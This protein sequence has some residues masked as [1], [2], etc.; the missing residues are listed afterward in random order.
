MFHIQPFQPKTLTDL[1]H[2][3]VVLHPG[4]LQRLHVM[5]SAVVVDQFPTSFGHTS[6]ERHLVSAFRKS[7]CQSF[8][9][10]TK[11]SLPSGLGTAAGSRPGSAVSSPPVCCG[12][13]PTMHRSPAGNTHIIKT[14]RHASC[15]QPT[16]SHAPLPLC[17]TS[18]HHIFPTGSSPVS[19]DCGLWVRQV[20]SIAPPNYTEHFR[21]AGV[22]ACGE[23]SDITL[24]T[25]SDLHADVSAGLQTHLTCP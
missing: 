21:G 23:G 2:L 19:S 11:R 20:G 5:P 13:L 16:G 1:H 6:L 8:S 9:S 4:S 15:V 22:S 7:A 25:M 24:C 14:R 18:S 12:S 17:M 3:S 10:E